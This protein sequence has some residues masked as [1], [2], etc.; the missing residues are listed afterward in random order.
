MAW[1]LTWEMDKLFIAQSW[2]SDKMKKR[3]QRVYFSASR[4][5]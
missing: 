3:R 1:G 2:K 5:K 4:G